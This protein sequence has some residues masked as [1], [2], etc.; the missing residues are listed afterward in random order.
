MPLFYISF[1]HQTTTEELVEL[2][3]EELFY[4]S[5][6]HQTTTMLLITPFMVMLFYISFL[7]Q[8]TTLLLWLQKFLLLFYISFLHQTTT[9]S[10]EKPSLSELFYI[11]FLHQT[12]T[13]SSFCFSHSGCF[14]SRFY[15]KPQLQELSSCRRIVVLYLVSTSNHN[16]LRPWHIVRMLFYISFL[17]QTTTGWRASRGAQ[18]LF[19]IS[20]LHQTT[21]ML[22]RLPKLSSCFISR[23]YIKPQQAVDNMKSNEVVLYLVSTSN[24]N[25]NVTQGIRR[26]VVLYLVSTS[27]HNTHHYDAKVPGLFYISFLHQTTTCVVYMIDK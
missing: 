15:I 19:Y 13:S 27:N 11:S 24:H 10:C 9:A 22:R 6:L 18:R 7:H 17:H 2:V 16:L 12:T 4:I 20:F 23:F 26:I 5:F 21:T 1:L 14:I 8:T 25:F 3:G